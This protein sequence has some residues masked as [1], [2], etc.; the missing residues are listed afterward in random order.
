MRANYLET[1]R[2]DL[3]EELYY[4]L[5]FKMTYF[6]EQEY[7]N[8]TVRVM[9]VYFRKIALAEKKLDKDCFDF[10]MEEMLSTLISFKSKSHRSIQNIATMLENYINY[11]IEKKVSTSRINSIREI[12]EKNKLVLCVDNESQ[13][14]IHF[15]RE[16]IF[17]MALASKNAQDGVILALLFEGVSYKN[18]FEELSNI[19]LDSIDLK[20][21]QIHF[22]SRDLP[23]EISEETAFL[24]AKA[25][26][27]T[28]YYSNKKSERSYDITPNNYLLRGLRNRGNVPILAGVISQR[29]L[30]IADYYNLEYLNASNISTSGMVYNAH[31]LYMNQKNLKNKAITITLAK[32]NLPIN[33]AAIFKLKRTIREYTGV[34]IPT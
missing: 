34:H 6:S 16:Q 23:F 13:A 29:I 2:K 22:K 9:R 8:S 25:I 18:E 19:T 5:D 21:R 14:K 24:V 11:A 15:S 7:S 20:N 28:K 1:N 27:D 3:E 31:K 12:K 17:Q 30:E 33:K 32:F 4:N 26:S 10:N